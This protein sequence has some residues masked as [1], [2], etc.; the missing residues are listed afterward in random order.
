M[1]GSVTWSR[2]TGLTVPRR[3]RNNETY[4]HTLV[5]SPCSRHGVAAMT[6]RWFLDLHIVTIFPKGYCLQERVASALRET[7]SLFKRLILLCARM[8]TCT[9]THTPS[10]CRRLWWSGEGVGSTGIRVAGSCGLPLGAGNWTRDLCKGH[11][12]SETGLSL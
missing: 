12:C 7:Y 5:S 6:K 8:N 4:T 11:K 1:C 2:N 3:K 10:T 9:H